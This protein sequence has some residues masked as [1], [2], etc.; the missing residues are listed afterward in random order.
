M[1]QRARIMKR[2]TRSMP[3]QWVVIVIAAATLRLLQLN[4]IFL[5][6]LE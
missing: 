4:T 5:S 1:K 6:V 3:A 2:E